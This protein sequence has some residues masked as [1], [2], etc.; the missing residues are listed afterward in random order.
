MF[1]RTEIVA[2]FA[3]EA[4]FFRF[5]VI[6]QACSLLNEVGDPPFFYISDISKSSTL[7]GKSLRKKSMLENFRANVLK[8]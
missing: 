6:F 3:N 4:R 1:G 2:L 5:S 7:S 8:A